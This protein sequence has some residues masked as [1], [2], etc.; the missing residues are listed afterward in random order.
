[1]K[2]AQD[3]VDSLTSADIVEMKTN[4]TPLDIIKYILDSVCVLFGAKLLPVTIEDKVF[5][6]KEG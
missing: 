1:M 2:R 6:R 4:K 3:A 5:N